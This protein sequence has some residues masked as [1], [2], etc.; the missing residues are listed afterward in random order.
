MNGL[1]NDSII[2]L[3]WFLWQTEILRQLNSVFYHLIYFLKQI[4][5]SEHY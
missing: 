4:H 2:I 1:Y 5:L 3:G